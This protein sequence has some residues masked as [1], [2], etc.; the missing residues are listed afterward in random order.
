MTNA[1]VSPSANPGSKAGELVT[2]LL[3]FTARR[4]CSLRWLSN[5]QVGKDRNRRYAAKTMNHD[6]H[7]DFTLLRQG[8]KEAVRFVTPS[9]VTATIATCIDPILL[10]VL[11]A[12]LE[13]KLRAGRRRNGGR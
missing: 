10:S 9:G 1:E 13:R 4:N 2:R 11:R 3:Q 8:E 5:V 12:K 6:K 7:T